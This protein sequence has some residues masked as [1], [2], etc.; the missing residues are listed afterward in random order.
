MGLLGIFPQGSRSQE[1]DQWERSGSR[2]YFAA[3]T[4]DCD[5]NLVRS[6][7]GADFVINYPHPTDASQVIALIGVTQVE[8]PS[9]FNDPTNDANSL[10]GTDCYWWQVEIT[11]GPWDPL[12]H[13][14]TGDPADQPIDFSFDWQVFEQA[15][16][17][18][19]TPGT[20]TIVPVVN[21]AGIPFDPPVTRE[22]I[23][24][25]LRVAWNAHTFNPYP[26][27][28]YGNFINSDTWN[29]FPP[30][31]VK[32]SPP[33]MPQRLWSQFLQANYYRLEAEFCFSTDPQGWNATPID[34]SYMALDGSGNLYKI[35][36][37]N[38]QPVSQPSLL[39]G[40]GAVLTIL[41]DF[42][43]FNYQIYQS[44]SFNTAFSNL[45][46]LFS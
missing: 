16:D 45:T 44:T 24:G 41:T 3:F 42:Y 43:Q 34:R 17:Y 40:S 33:K 12:T 11:Y 7:L 46:S 21:S 13:T 23:K 29:G 22:F 19:Y 18:A 30:Y 25:V 39:N 9:Q 14:A 4:T 15:C 36:D 10:I 28:A 6:N 1:D 8:E 31:S 32:F 38:G 2:K 20:T 27:F 26:F 35:L 37:I 5:E